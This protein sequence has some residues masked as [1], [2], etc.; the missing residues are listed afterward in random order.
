M[1]LVFVPIIIF[2]QGDGRIMG[3]VTDSQTGEPLIGANVIIEGTSLGAATDL[4]G[5][6]TINNVSAGVYTLK[7]S[8]L[9]F[10][11]AITTNIRVTSSLTTDISF[12]LNS[13][14]ISTA[15]V[16]VVA[17]KELI[18]KD[19]TSSIRSMGSDEIDELPIRGVTDI[20]A[21]APGVVQYNNEIHIRGGRE[22]E[23]GYYLEG[24]SVVNPVEGGRAVSLGNDALEEIQVEAGGFTAEYGGANSGIVRTQLRSGGSEFHFSLDYYTDNI[25][26]QSVNDFYNQNKRL[27]AYWYGKNESSF[28]ISGPV[29]QKIK[30]FYN[31][32]YQFDRSNAKRGYPGFNYG[33]ISDGYNDSLNLIYPK[34]VRKNQKNEA[35][36]NSGTIT[37]DFNPIRIRLAGTYTTGKSDVG[38][39]SIFALENNR[40]SEN[41]YKNGAFSASVSHVLSD[42]LFYKVTAGFFF[43]NSEVTD[44]YL[45]A[46]YWSYGD[47]LANAKA[48]ANTSNFSSRYVNP[49]FKTFYGWSFSQDGLVS[50]NYSKNSTAGL[51]GRLDFTWTPNKQNYIKAGVDLKQSNI[52]NWSISRAGGQ[53]SFAFALNNEMEKLTNPTAA[54]V[55]KIKRDILYLYGINN[56]GYDLFGNSIDGDGLYAPHKPVEL[57]V[58]LQDKIELDNLILNVGLR[59][60]YFDMDNKMLADKTK[61]DDFVGTV[62][63]DGDSFDV[64]KLVD[65]PTYSILTPRLSAAFP[66]TDK[67]V[68]H[69]GF[70]KYV[71][72]P[73]LDQAYLGY[74][75]LAYQFGQSFFFSSPTGADLEPVR[76]T[77]YEVGF[78]QELTSFM[79]M[80][81]T[82]YYDDIKGQVFFS[83]QDTDPNSSYQSYTTKVNGDFA[84][85]KGI[86]VVFTMR[87]FNR[88]SGNVSF[89]F[90][91]GSGTG[92]YPNS[93]SGIVGAPLDGVTVFKPNYVSPLT[94]TNP[95]QVIFFL[96]YRFADN[97]GG[98]LQNSGIS[99]LGNY[100]SGHPFT[101]GVGGVN[102]E[103]DSRFRQPIEPLN[104]SLTP[105]YFNLDL[106]VDKTF[107]IWD[108]LSL[109]VNLRVINLF[110]TRNVLDVYTRSG[111]ADDDGYLA[112][113]QLGGQLLDTYGEKYR[114]YYKSLTIDYNGFYS[115]A[116]Q[117]LL[118]F[119]LEY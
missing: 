51:S 107:K 40:F 105:S 64:N 8:F 100:N 22:D 47:S 49:I 72:M 111:A 87:R 3:S 42:K 36:I 113:P 4:N 71:Q 12:K 41:D 91:N 44:P 45:G 15:T 88:M 18:K 1:L 90:Q 116:R 39:S 16:T 50:T 29:T 30:V 6:Y 31:L 69:A 55:N 59:W 23:V 10:Q 103:T 17:Q 46:D 14:D 13:A 104:A 101:R 112:D 115:E 110:D 73:S 108:R 5:K 89:T 106:K 98:F 62:W 54:Q 85:T 80:D 19:A 118:G 97:D 68:F 74:H 84:T 25:T 52:R 92:S 109:N 60:D 119:S 37:M 96:D 114:D 33:N 93:N 78:R 27:G 11:N 2:G 61:P 65:V 58:Y 34:G 79:A 99:V 117:I 83:L 7:A 35:Y 76:K 32:N 56:Y 82:G 70:G 67:T 86:E 20:I 66:V 77:H 95:I 94:Y 24:V 57:G 43:T 26:M 38:G 28:S 75:A 63:N 81:I 53:R 48:G 21:L 102:M 9:G